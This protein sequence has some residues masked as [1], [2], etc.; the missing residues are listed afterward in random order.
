MKKFILLSLLIFSIVSGQIQVMSTDPAQH[1]VDVSLKP[2]IYTLFSSY[3]DTETV[4]YQ[5]VKVYGEHSGLK[6]GIFN[7]GYEN[8]HFIPDRA[9]LS[10][11][12][13]T[14]TLTNQIA[15]PMHTALLTPFSWQFRT[16]SN[17]SKLFFDTLSIHIDNSNGLWIRDF[18]SADVDNDSDQDIIATY[19][20][21]DKIGILF[22]DGNWDF[23]NQ[24]FYSDIQMP[25]AIV[26]FDFDNDFDVDVVC[27]NSGKLICLENDGTGTFS[28]KDNYNAGSNFGDIAYGDFDNDGDFD[29]CALQ[30]A[31]GSSTG[32][33]RIYKNNGSG[34]FVFN[35]T[36]SGNF[37][38]KMITGDFDNDGDL[39]I[40]STRWSSP[41]LVTILKNA[42]TGSFSNYDEINVRDY[43]ND[44]VCGDFDNDG[45]LDL[46]VN[47][48]FAES[49]SILDN[50]GEANF[51]QIATPAVGFE[52]TSITVNDFNGDGWLDI[53]AANPVLNFIYI[54]SNT[55]LGNFNDSNTI[56]SGQGSGPAIIKSGDYN[57]DGNI[58]FVFYNQGLDNLGVFQQKTSLPSILVSDTQI[59]F[60]SVIIADSK[61][62]NLII[63]NQGFDSTLVITDILKSSSNFSIDTTA[64]EI[65]SG[66]NYILTITFTP[67]SPGLFKDN[68]K[69]INNDPRKEELIVPLSG[70][71]ELYTGIHSTAPAM[72]A[73]GVS[74]DSDIKITFENDIDQ[75]NISDNILIY[76]DKYSYYNYDY[77]YNSSTKTLILV[78]ERRFIFGEKIVIIIHKNLLSG[79]N[80]YGYRFN[81]YIECPNGSGNF[82]FNNEL[83][84][85]NNPRI[86]TFCDFN[87]DGFVDFAVNDDNANEIHFYINI[88]SGGF[89]DTTWA[90]CLDP[91]VNFANGD[92]N[93]DGSM[94]LVYVHDIMNNDGVAF[95]TGYGIG[96]VSSNGQ[97][98]GQ[99]PIGLD[100]GDVNNDGRLDVVTTN[101][102]DNTVTV[103]KHDGYWGSLND[104]K[105][106]PTTFF[107]NGAVPYNCVLEDINND[108]LLDIIVANKGGNNI[109]IFQNKGSGIFDESLNYSVGQGPCDIICFDFNGDGWNDIISANQFSRNVSVLI[110]NCNGEFTSVNIQSGRNPASIFGHDFDSDADIDFAVLDVTDQEVY[111]Y[112]NDGN[113]TF[114]I[115]DT[116]P[117]G[118]DPVFI[119]GAD[120]DNN[121]TVAL[122]VTNTNGS[123]IIL[124][125]ELKSGIYLYAN[126]G[127]AEVSSDVEVNYSINNNLTSSATLLI[128][129]SVDNGVSWNT[130]TIEGL[131]NPLQS[132]QYIGSFI[133][134]TDN[135]LPQ[136]DIENVI[137]RLIPQAGDQFGDTKEI[138]LHID[139]NEIP[140]ISLLAIEEEQKDTVIIRYTIKDIENDSISLNFEYKKSSSINWSFP[141]IEPVIADSSHYD[142]WIIWDTKKDIPEADEISIDF[143]VTPRD[144]DSGMSDQIQFLLDNLGVPKIE[145]TAELNQELS[146][147]I[148]FFYNIFDD[149]FDTVF[150]RAEYTWPEISHWEFADLSGSVLNLDSTKYQGT[151]Y[152][153]S[154]T[155]IPGIDCQ[156]IS[157]R[158]TPYDKND[159]QPIVFDHIHIDN[160][161]IPRVENITNPDTVFSIAI[162]DYEISDPELDSIVLY[163]HWSSDSGTTWNPATMMNGI[164]NNQYSKYSGSLKW[165]TFADIGFGRRDN[166][167]FR[168][169]PCDNDSGNAFINE[170]LVIHNFLGEFSGNSEINSEDL[171]I[172]ASA[173]NAD[174]QI[175]L[176]ETGPANGVP[177]ELIPQPD[178]VLDFEDLMVFI[179][180]W[181]WSFENNGFVSKPVLLSKYSA[182]L[183]SLRLVQRYVDDP[184]NSD[185]LITIDVYTNTPELMMI[186]GLI[187]IDKQSLK[188]N[189]VN[190]GE[191]LKQSFQS[192]PLLTRFSTDSSLM[193]IAISGLGKNESVEIFDVPVFT[194]TMKNRTDKDLQI[195]FDYTLRDITGEII[196]TNSVS[197][198]LVSMTPQDFTLS[199]NYPNPFNSSTIIENAIPEKSNVSVEIYDLRGYKVRS[200]V[201][202]SHE[203][204]YYRRLWD[205]KDDNGRLVASGLYFMRIVAVGE[206]RTFTKTKKMVM[207]R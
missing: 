162:F 204:H 68:L 85:F 115:S 24:V 62:Q 48:K 159:G 120:I 12:M 103:L 57:G 91:V 80:D 76:G 90:E 130:P 182:G 14:V 8:F 101:R 58:D 127:L 156:N 181:N 154:T 73:I 31:A 61:Q 52:C 131:T 117:A 164:E 60:G 36:I 140:E 145:I 50:D 163:C 4:S 6:P 95:M 144:N 161:W 63:Y 104:L 59:D 34:D 166:T 207:I 123:I 151:F 71:G 88:P 150:I 44:I 195:S 27:N 184:W 143:R 45:D 67:D 152:W 147:S 22:N 206:T 176:Y 32:E 94:D 122:M 79:Y 141:T 135:D 170:I 203:A 134:K 102:G 114:I 35:S 198:T 77:D 7:I 138:L 96:F 153:N 75:D 43:A 39:D 74:C 86:L 93:Q 188:I 64:L 136:E 13:V 172:F 20:N 66:E 25:T 18:V 132:D 193:S 17:A 124:K 169:I 98:T 197:Q 9:F 30:A 196:E 183:P 105:Y 128:D 171:A 108:G 129:F 38:T 92:L 148:Q 113:A 28:Q 126:V 167:W 72:N 146:D 107:S 11:E 2:N 19:Y 3:I 133:W 78:P 55:G 26:C 40:A 87:R 33:I 191:Y 142:G 139:N 5:S 205:A 69:I 21:L 37:T 100:I 118:N 16:A 1:E 106:S 81:F 125:N 116:L 110:N 194:I 84:G 190:G 185:G 65:A 83:S 54:L 41:G 111:I 180:M 56:F 47:T 179:Q 23:S 174:P 192:T 46:A 82:N 168:I 199:N 158:V 201:D 97:N 175:I 178:G 165:F 121:G 157:F 200:L 89:F 10:G 173:W 70:T 15:S 29:V 109:S 177:P 186:D 42:G 187:N 53:A 189:S 112:E 49:I 149:E 99:D 202:S 137:L 155:D 119:S 160:N 51:T